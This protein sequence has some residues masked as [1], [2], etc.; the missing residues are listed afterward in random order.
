M[1][2]TSDRASVSAVKLELVKFVLVATLMDATSASAIPEENPAVRNG[3]ASLGQS[4]HW[5]VSSAGK[6]KSLVV[7]LIGNLDQTSCAA[8]MAH[9]PVSLVAVGRNAPTETTSRALDRVTYAR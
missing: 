9:G 5:N 7:I 1:V 2:L 3:L 8:Q 6:R 4:N